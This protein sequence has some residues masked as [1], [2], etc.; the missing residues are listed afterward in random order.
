MIQITKIFNILRNKH[1]FAIYRHIMKNQGVGQKEIGRKFGAVITLAMISNILNEMTDAGFIV[2]ERDGR[3]N[4]YSI[5]AE[6]VEQGVKFFLKL[7]G[8]K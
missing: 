4:N 8:G 6:K 3:K 5:G 1:R 2:K 7:F